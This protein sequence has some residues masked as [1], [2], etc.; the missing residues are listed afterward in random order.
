[1]CGRFTL[2]APPG[3]LF[4]WF[5]IFD[6][7]EFPPRYNIAPTQPIIVV[8]EGDGPRRTELMRW[9]LMPNWVKDPREFPL[10]INARAET[11]LEKPSFRGALR[12]HRCIIPATGYYEWRTGP[13]GKKQPFYITLK[14][15][16]PIAFAGV[17]AS[18]MGPEG[19]EIDSAA[20]VT[21]PASDDLKE[22]HHRMPVMLEQDQIADWLN[23]REVPE[24]EAFQMLKPLPEGKTK[25]HPVSRRVNTAHDD[26]EKLVEEVTVEKP[27]PKPKPK[28]KSSGQMDLF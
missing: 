9:G 3:V 8:L 17:W 14:D 16:A 12:H 6:G 1:M 19:E 2:T 4:E 15:G 7:P 27:E 18:W 20:I 24:K 5:D 11:I 26:D 22:V 28:K 10:I 23:V 13:D 21:V 25:L